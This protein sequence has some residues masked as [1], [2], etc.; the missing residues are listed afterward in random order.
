MSQWGSCH[1]NHH[2]CDS[3]DWN[4]SVIIFWNVFCT[5][6]SF[7]PEFWYVWWHFSQASEAFFS[8]WLIF[9]T[10][11]LGILN[12]PNHQIQCCSS[13]YWI[14]H[15]SF[16]IQ[17]FH[18]AFFSPLQSF[19]SLYKCSLCAE[20]YFSSLAIVSISN[21]NVIKKGPGEMVQRLKAW[22]VLV[23][24]PSSVPSISV[25]NN[26]LFL[27]F[28]R[29]LYPLFAYVVT[30]FMYTNHDTCTYFL[31]NFFTKEK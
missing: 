17:S 10:L 26:P 1:S 13:L 19:T 18:L 20:V 30:A 22:A 27:K 7:L 24:N 21:W 11:R 6:C 12:F 8:F 9:L 15:L 4:V 31:K 16:Q 23:E 5:F 25:A 3:S 28:Q 14:S 2:R 29:I